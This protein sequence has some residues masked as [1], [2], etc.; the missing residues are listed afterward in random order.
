M[1][2]EMS[3]K[4]KGME[5]LIKK[6]GHL[7]NR[8]Q[9][10]ILRK[11][12][13]HA[14]K[15]VRTMARRLAPKESGLLKK[16]IGAKIKVQMSKRIAYAVVGPRKGQGKEVAITDKGKVYLDT[17]EKQ[18][19]RNAGRNIV[20]TEFRDPAKYAHIVERGS[21]SHGK[22]P[23]TGAVPFLRKA[24]EANKRRVLGIIRD[25]I[26]EELKREAAKT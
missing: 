26:R 24:F 15:P 5:K 6:M 17:T 1:A 7:Q 10:R 18:R 3:M 22:H 12:I 21:A 9:S 19:K 23:G 20:K 25:T 8:V 4:I 13:R 2:F 11:A 14:E 16:S